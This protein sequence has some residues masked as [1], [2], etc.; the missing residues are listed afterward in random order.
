[1]GAGIRRRE[2][3]EESSRRGR[4][5]RWTEG[6][7]GDLLGSTF[8]WPGGPGSLQ[9][10]AGLARLVRWAPSPT[11]ASL[12]FEH[13]LED[14]SPPA[15]AYTP[16]AR[17]DRLL[18]RPVC[19]P[20]RTRPSSGSRS[21][22]SSRPPPSAT[23]RRLRSTPSTCSPSC[24]TRSTTASPA[25]S[26]RRVSPPLVLPLVLAL[27]PTNAPGRGSVTCRTVPSDACRPS[28]IPQSSGSVR[29]TRTP[30]T[31]ATTGPLPSVPASVTASASTRPSRLPPP[32]SS[33]SHACP[34]PRAFYPSRP[35][36]PQPP[37][38]PD[39]ANEIENSHT[40]APVALRARRGGLVAKE[41]TGRGADSAC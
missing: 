22:T 19:P 21:P 11:L 24:T 5:K 25:R 14:R 27:L 31:R 1:M 6:E 3:E 15:V 41:G 40:N 7:Q 10:L 8:S 37:P 39:D 13:R 35:D 36:Y 34:P 2:G 4:R 30:P 28:C 12:L 17:P 16:Q 9:L 32:R 20:F 18:P 33:K 38:Q 26:T 23:C 29:P